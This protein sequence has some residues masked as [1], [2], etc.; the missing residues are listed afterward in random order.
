MNALTLICD[1]FRLLFIGL[2]LPTQKREKMVW[3]ISEVVIWP[4]TDARW[5][6]VS[7]RSW[8]IRSG[9]SWV[10][11]P[12]STAL[13]DVAAAESAWAWRALVTIMSASPALSVILVQMSFIDCFNV[14]ISL[15]YL[16]EMC[17]IGAEGYVF[18]SMS[19]MLQ[20]SR[21]MSLL[22]IAKMMRSLLMPDSSA[23]I[24][25]GCVFVGSMTNIT[26]PA[27]RAACR[28]RSMPMF[29]MVSDV[30]RRP[31]VSLKRMR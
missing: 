3:S 15:R 13:A 17:T 4:V 23:W 29:S 30:L 22:F 28:E 2:Y 1:C 6:I 14:S 7:R 16:A 25:S 26:S 11:S 27:V 12:S 19:S 18:E 21:A 8:A 5:W 24:V 20:S 9:G 10:F 31:A